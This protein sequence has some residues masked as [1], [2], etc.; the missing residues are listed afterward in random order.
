M[1]S[2]INNVLR[3]VAADNLQVSSAAMQELIWTN[4]RFAHVARRQSLPEA[5]VNIISRIQSVHSGIPAAD[6]NDAFAKLREQARACLQLPNH[7]PQGLDLL[8]RTDIRNLSAA[9]RSELY[10]TKAE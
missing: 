2:H 10:L 1:F 6:L 9:Q 7:T 3:N 4:T 5:C 8:N